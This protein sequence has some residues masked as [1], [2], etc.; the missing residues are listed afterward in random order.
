[1]KVLKG[2][3][4]TLGAVAAALVF[5]AGPAMADCHH[6]KGNKH[7]HHH[8]NSQGVSNNNWDDDDFWN[9]GDDDDDFG[10]V[11]QHSHGNNGIGNGTQIFAPV[12][13]PT[14][15]CGNAIAVLGAASGGA[16]CVND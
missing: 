5:T 10:G 6:H 14:N 12:N 9:N 2:T 3:V 1:M 13:I 15:I 8:S 4:V 7:K 11:S 16:I